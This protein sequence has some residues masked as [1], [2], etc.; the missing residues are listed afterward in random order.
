M[1]RNLILTIK[2]V[3]KTSILSE[4]KQCLGTYNTLKNLFPIFNMECFVFDSGIE[5]IL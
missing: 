4:S 3:R 5:D 1:G 2:T